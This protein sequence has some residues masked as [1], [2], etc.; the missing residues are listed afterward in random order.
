MSHF[1]GI[2]KMVICDV[3]EVDVECH[4]IIHQNVVYIYIHTFFF[5]FEHF[6]M[7]A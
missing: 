7:K 6:S 3:F 1:T 5:P 2:L 4:G